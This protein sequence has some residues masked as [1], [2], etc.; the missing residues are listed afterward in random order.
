MNQEP[1]DQFYTKCQMLVILAHIRADPERLLG[2]KSVERIF[3]FINGVSDSRRDAGLPPVDLSPARSLGGVLRNKHGMPEAAWASIPNILL[4]MTGS[5]EASYM[6]FWR[7]L[8]QLY[9]SCTISI[10]CIDDIRHLREAGGGLSS[11]EFC[12]L[13]TR[14]RESTGLRLGAQ[15][16]TRLY[17]YL[18][19]YQWDRMCLSVPF[20]WC[21]TMLAFERWL[22]RRYH[23]TVPVP[24]DRMISLL[25]QDKSD[26]FHHF[27]SLW[28]EFLEGDLKDGDRRQG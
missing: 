10:T 3:S 5:E 2:S 22:L 18:S 9:P 8:D 12:S 17:A 11:M 28:E 24:W 13:L 26:A 27:F 1:S 7:E 25:A 16:L 4:L 19:G 15:S 20:A 14:I 6:A 21:P 23:I